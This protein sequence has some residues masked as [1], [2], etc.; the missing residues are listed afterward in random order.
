MVL[1]RCSVVVTVRATGVV[2]SRD[3][4]LSALVNLNWTGMTPRL[5]GHV[6]VPSGLMGCWIWAL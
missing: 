2:T 3:S 5:A 1:V 6:E 4:T